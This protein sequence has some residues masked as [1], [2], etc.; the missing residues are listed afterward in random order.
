M[1]DS[2]AGRSLG[3]GGGPGLEGIIGGLM[4][5]LLQQGHEHHDEPELEDEAGHKH[6]DQMTSMFLPI[7]SQVTFISSFHNLVQGRF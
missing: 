6:F 1:G 3:G 2:G 4:P 7:I 5:L